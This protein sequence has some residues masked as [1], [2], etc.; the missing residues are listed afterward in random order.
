MVCDEEIIEMFLDIK[1][2][3]QLRTFY[4]D[5]KIME[6]ESLRKI[7]KLMNEYFEYIEK[8]KENH[9]LVRSEVGEKL[10][11]KVKGILSVTYDDFE[12]YNAAM[13]FYSWYYNTIL[14][15]YNKI[16]ADRKSTR[17]N[18]SH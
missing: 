10:L 14:A 1:C 2:K 18:S 12:Y 11:K 13:Y 4:F 7:K 16:N 8:C 5:D 15:I 17:L 9:T 3:K 6:N